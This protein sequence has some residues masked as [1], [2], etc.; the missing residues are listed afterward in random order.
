MK[1]NMQCWGFRLCY[2]VIFDCIWSLTVVQ[3]NRLVSGHTEKSRNGIGL[4]T[5]FILSFYLIFDKT[6]L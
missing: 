1:E 2:L 3:E 4:A 5:Q 6:Y